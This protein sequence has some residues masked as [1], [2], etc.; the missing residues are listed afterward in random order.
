MKVWVYRPD[1]AN[2]NINYSGLINATGQS[3]PEYDRDKNEAY[4]YKLELLKE[5]IGRRNK[6]YVEDWW[7]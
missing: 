7:R 1:K 2:R 3:Y 4:Q 5:K 6:H